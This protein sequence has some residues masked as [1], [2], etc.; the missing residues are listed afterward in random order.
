[1]S[2]AEVRIYRAIFDHARARLPRLTLASICAIL[3][4]ESLPAAFEMEEALFAFGPYAA[5]FNAARWDLKA[6]LIEYA[7]TNPPACGPTASTW[8]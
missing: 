2:I 3:L 6:S 8:I 7:M 4:V 5:G 1:V